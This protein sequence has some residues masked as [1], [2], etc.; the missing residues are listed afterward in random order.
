MYLTYT[1]VEGD[2]AS[3]SIHAVNANN[4]AFASEVFDRALHKYSWTG[5]DKNLKTDS[6]TLI[7][8]NHLLFFANGHLY[9]SENL[10]DAFNLE[11]SEI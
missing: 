7:R 9:I 3:L 2:I 8:W 10:R 5:L 1:L 11:S 4:N 6:I